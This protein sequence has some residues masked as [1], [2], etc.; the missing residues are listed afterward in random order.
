M[1]VDFSLDKVKITTSYINKISYI[2][3]RTMSVRLKPN[4]SV[5][6]EPI[7]LYSSGNIPTG[8]EMV[9]IL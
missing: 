5:T 1:K 3:S 6:A 2:H 9:L 8:P 7:G 4:I